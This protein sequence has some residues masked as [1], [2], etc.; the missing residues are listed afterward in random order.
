VNF[1]LVL[2]LGAASANAALHE[3]LHAS[4]ADESGDQCAVVLFA[5]GITLAA[6][7]MAV[8]APAAQWFEFTPQR[9][10]EI[11][12]VAPR[13]LRQPERGPPYC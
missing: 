11:F 7:A 10:S 3:W 6:A 1:G 8:A 4:A 9:V 12:L 5:S 2:M 13:Y